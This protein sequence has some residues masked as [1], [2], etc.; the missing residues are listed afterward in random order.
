MKGE[1]IVPSPE[2]RKHFL[3]NYETKILVPKLRAMVEELCGKQKGIR[4]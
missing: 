4:E 1:T 3:E 2:V